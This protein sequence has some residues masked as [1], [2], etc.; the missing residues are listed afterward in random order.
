MTHK[1][2]YDCKSN[3]SSGSAIGASI[4]G[5]L[6]KV[7]WVCIWGH[8]RIYFCPEMDIFVRNFSFFSGIFKIQS[9]SCIRCTPNNLLGLVIRQQISS[10]FIQQVFRACGK[11]LV[12]KGQNSFFQTLEFITGYRNFDFLTFFIVFSGEFNLGKGFLEFYLRSPLP[13]RNNK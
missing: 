13:L 12:K 6:K 10:I 11:F 7:D 2:G 4:F 5:Y 1:L 8:F 9:N 3:N